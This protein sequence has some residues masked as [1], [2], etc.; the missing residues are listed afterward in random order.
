MAA[1]VK[2]PADV[3][4][5]LGAWQAVAVDKTSTQETR[6]SEPATTRMR[7]EDLMSRA[8]SSFQP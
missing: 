7:P 4:G 1:T 2:V 8:E 6:R 3:P 5:K